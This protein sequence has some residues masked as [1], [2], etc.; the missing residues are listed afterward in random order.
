MYVVYVYVYICGGNKFMYVSV[1]IK[2][3][4]KDDCHPLGSDWNFVAEM[5]GGIS[6]IYDLYMSSLFVAIWTWWEVILIVINLHA[7]YI[8]A[9]IE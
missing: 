4:P 1:G 5:S 3:N 2:L 8:Y 9:I 7:V 6:Y